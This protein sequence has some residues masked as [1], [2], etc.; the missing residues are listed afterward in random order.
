MFVIAVYIF[1]LELLSHLL[2]CCRM[3]MCFQLSRGGDK[4]VNE[5][6]AGSRQE[7]SLDDKWV[8]EFSNLNVQDWAGEFEHA[9]GA[10]GEDTING[11]ASAYDE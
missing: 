11:W 3:Q 10:A 7:L 8:D 1:W 4:W 5:F 2:L 9:E 6:T